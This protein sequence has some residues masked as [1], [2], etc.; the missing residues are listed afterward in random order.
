MKFIQSIFIKKHIADFAAI[1]GVLIYL[2][3]SIHFASTQ[4][5]TIDEGL[6]L[7][8]GYLFA[9]GAY[10]PFQDYGPRTSYGP[11]SYLVPGYIQL[12]F[13]PGLLTGRI[14]TII[15]GILA[16]LGLWAAARR[17]AGSWWASGAVWVTALNPAVIRFYSFGLSQGLVTC[18]LMWSLFFAMGKNRSN[19]QTS[20]SAVLAGLLL[21]TRQN[22]APVLPIL[23]IYIF[24]Q[25]GRKQ[26][27]ISAIVGISIVVAGHI[28]F[29]PGILA[30]WTPW[31]PAILTP[32]LDAWRLPE[33]A[34][35]A[36]IFQ[37]T[38]SARFYSLMEG[39]RFHFVSLVGSIV[40]LV[41]WP[42]RKAWKSAAEF[43]S[44][45]FLAILFFS[46]LG[47][48]AW[49]GLGFS[50]GNNNNAFTFNPYLAFFDYAGLL[51]AIAV[52]SNS[53]RHL[54]VVNHIMIS[55]LIIFISTYF[56]YDIFENNSEFLLALRFPR[57]RNFITTW[58]LLP[59][60]VPLWGI[61][62]NKFSL[63]YETS[64]WLARV[65]TGFLSG[66]LILLIGFTIWSFMK[67]RMLIPSY[68]FGAISAAVF[69]LVGVIMSPTST[70]GGGFDQWDCSE[71]V[72]NSYEKVGQHLE[73]QIP[74]GS[75]VYWRG[76][77][78]VAVLLY[79]PG[80]RI[81]PAQLDW[82]WN[83]WIGGNPDSLAR[84]GYWNEE[85]AASWLENSDIVLT[86]NAYEQAAGL[87]IPNYP[88]YV[89][90]D[91]TSQGL[92]CSPD[93]FLL[94]YLRR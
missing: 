58:K 77:N 27:F 90:V 2:L 22:M 11:L 29:W 46:L 84:L 34:T 18:L 15:I 42:A 32:F 89:Q 26:G 50:A 33:G 76:G 53:K 43:R 67:R 88:E 4:R 12:W 72:I 54:P 13:G 52:L 36:L 92:N 35:P 31:L 57:I 86:Q 19:W 94:I 38:W 83:H 30:M 62:A 3:F 78:A 39:V 25:F 82:E 85:L 6:F 81:H 41:L 17:L 44:G 5:S 23:L 47:L 40:G 8:K 24:W 73:E 61:L 55:L 14:F 48:H 65:L 56:G 7:Y 64:L 49:A 80:I 68:S 28:I 74:L 20:L 37:P 21:L 10:H 75:T 87:V 59:G 51:F 60:D 70:L 66:L 79:T 16:L 45:V 69:M 93:S 63:T 71:N 91:Q 9:T 1:A